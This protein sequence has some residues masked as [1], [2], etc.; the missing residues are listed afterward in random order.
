[1][2]LKFQGD[3]IPHWPRPL[4]PIGA[5]LGHIPLSRALWRLFALI[6]ASV[7]RILWQGT[8]T[9]RR[10]RIPLTTDARIHW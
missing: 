7:T 8:E 6:F 5:V 9:I 3:V 10:L 4:Q 1:M 2:N